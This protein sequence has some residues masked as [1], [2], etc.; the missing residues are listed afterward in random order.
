MITGQLVN[1]LESF[2]VGEGVVVEKAMCIC[3]G[4]LA[5]LTVLFLLMCFLLLPGKLLAQGEGP[6][7]YLPAPTGTNVLS[8]TWMD[9]K[10]NMNFAGNIY[11]PGAEISSTVYALNYNRYFSMAGRLAEIW[12]TGIAGNVS[13]KA[14]TAPFDTRSSGTSGMGDPYVALR[15]GLTGA[16]A[17]KPADFMKTPPGFQLYALVGISLPWGEYN[18]NTPLNLGTNRWALRLGLPM[19]IPLGKKPG[20]NWLEIHPN[21][22]FYGDND[23]PFRADTRSQAALYV[24]ES[25]LTHNFTP[26]FWAGIDLRYQN[27]GETTTDGIRDDN[28]VD[29][30][31]GGISVGY[32]FSRSWNGFISYGDVITESDNSKMNMWRARLIWLF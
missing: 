5:R 29:R 32:A 2:I 8:A 18:Q 28:K 20:V 6:R 26:K 1:R 31:G 17:L 4:Q 16:P 21:V 19:T 30:L 7:V 23:E 15:V 14:Y 24:L 13:G 3:S 10:S 25:H 9:M 27:G 22:Y 12:A 11:I